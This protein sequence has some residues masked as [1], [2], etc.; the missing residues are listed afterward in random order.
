[1]SIISE[2]VGRAFASSNQ[3]SFYTASADGS[4]KV[5]AVESGYVRVSADDGVTW[6]DVLTTQINGAYI[7]VSPGGTGIAILIWSDNDPEL[8]IS[9]DTGATWKT[10][11]GLN[12]QTV[13]VSDGAAVTVYAQ[14]GAGQYLQR[15]ADGGATWANLTAAGVS[16]W[17]CVS[18]SADGSRIIACPYNQPIVVS[19][20]S[21]TTWYTSDS[22]S[23]AWSII[24]SSPDGLVAV[25]GVTG[26]GA[27]YKTVNGGL[28][29]SALSGFDPAATVDHIGVSSNGSVVITCKVN[30]P[31]TIMYS[32]DGGATSQALAPPESVY[33]IYLS[34]FSYSSATGEIGFTGKFD[35]TLWLGKSSGYQLDVTWGV[36]FDA[37]A[38]LTVVTASF[39]SDLGDMRLAETSGELIFGSAFYGTISIDG[40]VGLTALLSS[41]V[42]VTDV[43][44][45]D[46]A[47]Q[48]LIGASF[49][50]SAELP[51]PDCLADFAVGGVYSSEM[52][53]AMVLLDA[54]IAVGRNFFFAAS[55]KLCFVAASMQIGPVF[56]GAISTALAVPS[57]SFAQLGWFGL[58]S[59]LTAVWL[60]AMMR[61]EGGEAYE[62]W[63]VNAATA[64][65]ARYERYGFNSL[66]QFRGVVLAG[67]ADGLY[68]CDAA[69]DAGEELLGVVTTGITDMDA[70]NRKYV[71]DAVID[72]EGTGAFA[73]TVYSDSGVARVYDVNI[74]HT[75]L[76]QNKR[77]KLAK[78]ISSRYWSASLNLPPGISLSSV[79]LRVNARQ[80]S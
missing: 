11:T 57:A 61:F 79:T 77:V 10:V 3:C 28:T 25:A 38:T 34:R 7:D 60:D 65:H 18:V 52:T 24:E 42:L 21:G 72:C 49:S 4:V 73:L 20:D 15:S 51:L 29:W 33:Q 66:A 31:L 68:V 23:L 80:R 14:Y 47:C 54:E 53:A 39:L 22:P 63:V 8:R 17:G 67:K 2:W 27:V 40:G 75:G 74:D 36:G 1:M 76:H 48:L 35:D 43:A 30:Y 64:G 62:A 46:L 78:G 44:M 59:Q 58:E 71:P 5:V 9:G 56:S 13:A 50:L 69:D 70:P 45:P 19:D 26:S 55:T 6:S 37:A 32:D 41:A 12:P 16:T